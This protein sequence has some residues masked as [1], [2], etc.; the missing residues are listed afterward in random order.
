MR[1]EPEPAVSDELTSIEQALTDLDLWR[2]AAELDVVGYTVLPPEKAAP[3]GFI[4]K[5]RDQVLAVAEQRDGRAVDV[6]AGS[7]HLN[8][9]LPNYPYLLFEDPIFE[10]LLMQPTALTLVTR[11]LGMSCVLSA[12]NAL[13]KGPSVRE[14]VLDIPLHSDTE[15]HPPP[16][17]TFA[18]Y[19]NATW[20]LTDYTKE[21][22]ALCFVPGSHTLCR[23]PGPGE[24]LDQAVPVEAPMGSLVVWH[25]NTWHGAYPRRVEG[26]RIG[27]AQLFARR[28]LLPREPYRDDVT[29]E[30]LDRNNERFATL[31]GQD[32]V[33]G[34]RAEGPDYSRVRHSSVATLYS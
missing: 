9:R 28:Y 19:A 10:E 29:K 14:D 7:S 24:G 12:S 4:E 8:K 15:G 6:D 16:F 25:G 2:H 31:M 13:I 17:P 22:G 18:Q 32:I 33:A 1:P 3:A 5:V 27:L 26:L 21:G 23:Q 20:L 30:H 11:L 34:W